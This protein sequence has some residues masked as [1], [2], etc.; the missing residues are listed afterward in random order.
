MSLKYKISCV[1][2]GII[3][4]T[5]LAIVGVFAALDLDFK[6]SG[7]ITYTVPVKDETAYPN[8]KFEVLNENEKT[9]TVI[10]KTETT[11][12]TIPSQVIIGST[13]YKV[14]DIGSDAF[15]E[16]S[17]LTN[18]TIPDT[19]TSIGGSAFESCESLTSITIP[20]SVTSI[21][22]W[23]FA[24]C[25]SF[26]SI[27]IPNSVTSI[28]NDAFDYCT[29]LTYNKISETDEG[30]YL[31]NTTNPYL[32]LAD[33][34]TTTLT[35]YIIHKDCKIIGSYA[36]EDCTGLT[37]ITIPDSVTSI[38]SSAFSRC[39]GLTS[40]TIPNSVTSIG[41][42]AFSGCS[43]LT[44]NKISETDEGKY[45]GNTTNPY[46]Y[47]A[48]TETSTLTEY[49][50]HEDCKII[51]SEAFDGCSKLTSITIPDSVT[52]IGNGAF[53]DCFGL[54]SITIPAS[55]TSI[56][57]STFYGCSKL[58]SITIPASVTSI[59]N[60]AF[61]NCNSL[62]TVNYAGSETDWNNIA[63]GTNNK[64]ITSATINYNS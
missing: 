6:V 22:E 9:A 43:S 14:T 57:S 33:T 10:G 34:E 44:Y 29:S 28:G 27:T 32:Y 19:V 64:D 55:V 30:K 42:S 7:D 11:T 13:T 47:L 58:T 59:G 18:I 5:L 35:E 1:I 51:G 49:T 26:T 40:V 2:L 21:G 60:Y 8:L 38:G 20:N 56:G 25:S 4:T 31:G 53:S 61:S 62:T 50:I 36:F 52:S 45:L 17:T 3:L 16:W 39:R 41:N 46:L 23:A 12:I 37:S 63:I 24:Y 48:D 54:T 15:F